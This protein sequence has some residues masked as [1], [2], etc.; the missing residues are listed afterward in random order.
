MI[1]PTGGAI[2]SDSRGDGRHNAP[3]GIRR[4][5]GV[6][7]LATPGQ[8]VLAPISGFV[9]RYARPYANDDRYSGVILT[10]NSMTIKMFYIKPTVREGTTV[11]QGDVIGK[12]Q[13]VRLRHGD[14][15]L[16]H[17]HLR[18]TNVDPMLLIDKPVKTTD[19]MFVMHK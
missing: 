19:E 7:F 12:A 10:N 16:P 18:V 3:R 17:I 6:D 5:D 2:R 15:M 14:D 8:D 11:L 1:N 4:H 9:V 13:D